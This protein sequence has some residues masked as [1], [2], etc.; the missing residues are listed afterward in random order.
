MATG[1][2]DLGGNPRVTNRQR[3]LAAGVF[4]FEGDW[5]PDLR[6]KSSIAAMLQTVHEWGGLRY[7]RR[8]IGTTDELRYYVQKWLL[9][10]Y[11]K[12]EVGYFGFHGD[13]GNLWLDG[14]RRVSLEDLEHMI[15]GRATGRIIHFGSCSVM[16]TD[17]A[18]LREFHKSTGARAV[19]GYHNDV[20]DLDVVA[21]E[22][23]LLQALATYQR[24]DAP[25]K[26]LREWHPHLSE[27][28]GFEYIY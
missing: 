27:Y 10:R 1:D 22:L 24:V 5:N 7:I 3:Y 14:R 9:K 23:L 15:R 17:P 16:K 19:V 6:N 20:G 11:A 12:Y 28:L 8:D 2:Q 4:A 18:R 26:Y 13:P 25:A 21:F